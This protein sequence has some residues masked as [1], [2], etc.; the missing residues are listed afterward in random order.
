MYKVE[1]TYRLISDFT[2][3]EKHYVAKTLEEAYIWLSTESRIENAHRV[4][5][6]V[7]YYKSEQ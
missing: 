1:I 3:Y 7:E 5:T 4:R 6:S 2:T